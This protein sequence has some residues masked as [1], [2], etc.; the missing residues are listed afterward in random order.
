MHAT[1]AHLVTTCGYVC[2]F[3]RYPCAYFI[4]AGINV[5]VCS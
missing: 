1:L 4:K 5:A 3:A 2:L